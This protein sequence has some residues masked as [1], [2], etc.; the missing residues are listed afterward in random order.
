MSSEHLE[1]VEGLTEQLGER[2]RVAIHRALC[3][4]DGAHALMLANELDPLDAAGVWEIFTLADAGWQTAGM[5]FLDLWKQHPHSVL[6]CI[7]RPTEADTRAYLSHLIRRMDFPRPAPR[8]TR[9]WRGAPGPAAVVAR[10]L[11]WQHDR[12][13]A[14][15]RALLGPRPTLVSCELPVS[16]IDLCVSSLAIVCEPVT[17]WREETI[18]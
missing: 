18:G 13:D 10:G 1:I 9:L 3:L 16:Q 2:W 5:M 11:Q 12:Q 8:V 6:E 14:A 7:N 4:G 15:V 17:D